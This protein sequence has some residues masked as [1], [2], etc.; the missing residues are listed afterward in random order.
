MG[1]K[2][3]IQQVLLNLITNA[4]DAMAEVT[5]RPKILRI[6]AHPDQPDSVLIG[7]EDTGKGF[8][9]ATADQIF[10]PFYTT[11]SSGMGMGL[12]ICKTIVEAHG[13]Q[14]RASPNLQHGVIFEFRLPADR[15]AP[16]T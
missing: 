10:A 8:D 5:D 4:M 6:S 14:L 15:R 13:G 12:S 1:D 11:K 7:V 3:Q 2:V 9:P 16:D